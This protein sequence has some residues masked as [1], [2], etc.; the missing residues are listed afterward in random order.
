MQLERSNFFCKTTSFNWILNNDGNNCDCRYEVTRWAGEL[1]VEEEAMGNAL[2]H[3][4]GKDA[5]PTLSESSKGPDVASSTSS[6]LP[7]TPSSSRSQ[8]GILL[9]L[10]Q[11]LAATH[12]GDLSVNFPGMF[13]FFHIL[14][15]CIKERLSMKLHFSTFSTFRVKALA[16]GCSNCSS[17]NTVETWKRVNLLVGFH[18]SFVF[19]HSYYLPL[20]LF[21]D[22]ISD[23]LNST[24]ENKIKM[25]FSVYDLSGT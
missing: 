7:P 17:I 3:Q 24:R 12:R 21:K 13:V 15:L 16:E 10:F 19:V 4:L 1:F 18:F 11:E 14:V 22:F 2:G 6:L 20:F 25:L 8:D 5:T 23:Y 9:Q